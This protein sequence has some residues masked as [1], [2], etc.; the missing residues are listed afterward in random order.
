MLIDSWAIATGAPL[1]LCSAI[2]LA[3]VL[4]RLFVVLRKQG[5]SKGDNQAIFQALHKHEMNNALDILKHS[6]TGYQ[7]V[8]DELVHHK[9]STKEVRDEAIKIM[10]V[11]YSNRLKRRLSGLTTIASLAPMLGLLGTI[12]GLMRSFRDI[13]LSDGPVNPSIVADGLWQAL[14]TTA[15]GM[16]IAVVCVL[17]HALI[18]SRIRIHLAEAADVLN[19]FS[20]CIQLEETEHD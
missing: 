14:S 20:H 4:E 15:A 17:C 19:H 6:G 12:I 5:L 18:K 11:R 9:S 1:V 16:V 2:A 7:F 3:L 10:L 8:I 13:G